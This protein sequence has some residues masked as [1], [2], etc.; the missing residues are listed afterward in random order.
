MP[1]H[2][3]SAILDIAVIAGGA[4]MISTALRQLV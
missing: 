2:I 1:V 3:H 4:V